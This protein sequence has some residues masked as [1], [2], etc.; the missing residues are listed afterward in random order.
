[1]RLLD[2]IALSSRQQQVARSVVLLAPL[3][4]LA[5]VT[6]SGGTF[7][8]LLTVVGV[9]LAVLAA[10]VPETNAPLGVLVY[11]AATWAITSVG[12]LDG[13]TLLAA[14]DLFAL[15]LAATLASYGPP[16]LVLDADLLVLWRRRAVVC[17]AAAG[18]VW[19]VARL[20]AFLELPSSGLALGL[21]LLVFLAWLGAL[22]TGLSEPRPRDGP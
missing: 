8:P 18:G 6:L 19:L 22:T 4:F 14:V 13:W 9:L 16:G 5:L 7:H 1:M 21:A 17:L 3:V 2:R 11:L 12:A 15:H 20:L 10:L